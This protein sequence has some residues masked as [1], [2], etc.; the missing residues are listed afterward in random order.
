MRGLSM[1][2]SDRLAY[3]PFAAMCLVG[4]L[5]AL[6]PGQQVELSK[7]AI[8]AGLAL[9]VNVWR[10]MEAVRQRRPSVLPALLF[11]CSVGLL[12]DA[13]GGMIGGLGI[14]VLLPVVWTALHG[15][16][17]QL[18]TVVA[19]VVL[20]LA[21]PQ[22]AIGGPAYPATGWRSAILILT[23]ALITGTAVQRLVA[24][25]RLAAES[26][27]SRERE[28]TVLLGKLQAL[29]DTDALTEIPN[30]RSWQQRL[31]E[32][33]ERSPSLARG[34]CVALVDVDHF[35]ELNDRAGHLAGDHTLRACAEAWSIVLR[36]Q[37]TLARIGG[38]EFAVL[39]PD[40][41]LRDAH[42][43]IERLRATTPAN[44]TISAGLAE[45]RPGETREE[46]LARVDDALYA[47]KSNGR[48]Q[49]LSRAN[50]EP[51]L[52]IRAPG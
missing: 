48:N 19:A 37:D 18:H 10:A 25:L 22:L 13:G 17:R 42:E 9:V 14:L 20:T 16:P 21:V 33:L 52:S 43:I 12:R 31:D 3:M 27:E 36:P 11:L 7:Y 4:F 28:R 1:F 23:L 15:T 35:K 51:E 49:L 2:G 39:L 47:A 45:H 29:A 46:L 32:V 44:V 26:L 34:L 5:V 38:D 41:A 40:C 30:R 8:A 50:S 6:L 24:Q